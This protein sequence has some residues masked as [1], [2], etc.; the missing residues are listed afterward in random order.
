[1]GLLV[2]MLIMFLPLIYVNIKVSGRR[3]FGEEGIVIWV[4]GR[5][6]VREYSAINVI[7]LIILAVVREDYKVM[8]RA[9]L[10]YFLFLVFDLR[11]EEK[12]LEI[13][14]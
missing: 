2:L 6:M 14:K 5:K 7:M 9:I 10:L 8:L 11:D 3:E 13:L 4:K 1:M 12:E